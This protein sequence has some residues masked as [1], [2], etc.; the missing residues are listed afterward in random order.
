MQK[1]DL[2]K[3]FEILKD[4][5]NFD[6]TS[7]EWLDVLV[8]ELEIFSLETDIDLHINIIDKTNHNTRLVIDVEN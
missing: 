2:N 6:F 7:L 3:I 1:E 8:H 5:V 4:K